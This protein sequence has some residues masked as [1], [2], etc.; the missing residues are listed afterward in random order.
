M[1]DKCD[2]SISLLL[3]LDGCFSESP[4][5]LVVGQKVVLLVSEGLLV[6]SVKISKVKDILFTLV[7]EVLRN[8]LVDTADVAICTV[9]KVILNYGL[10]R[11]VF[12]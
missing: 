1:A 5:G 7:V 9:R 10:N 6:H 12:G 8:N 3:I 11:L 4:H 2:L